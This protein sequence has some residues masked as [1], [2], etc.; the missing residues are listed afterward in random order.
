MTLLVSSGEAAW[1]AVVA[2]QKEKLQ[3]EKS[4]GIKQF[5]LVTESPK[6]SSGNYNDL[7]K[8]LKY[9][10]KN[11]SDFFNK[12]SNLPLKVNKKSLSKILKYIK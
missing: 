10:E 7:K 9:L 2:M 12:L 8:I 11:K 6:Q 1:N 4:K 3:K 5:L